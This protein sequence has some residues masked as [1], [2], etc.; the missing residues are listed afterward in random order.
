MRKIYLS[1]LLICITFSACSLGKKSYTGT[2]VSIEAKR[3][4]S[5]LYFNRSTL[6]LHQLD[7]GA[8]KGSLSILEDGETIPFD[9]EEGYIDDKKVLHLKLKATVSVLF[10]S[11]DV[12]LCLDEEPSDKEGY[13]K[14]SAYL[15][16]DKT[17]AEEMVFRKV[18]EQNID[19]ELKKMKEA[20]IPEQ[21]DYL[22][23][24]IDNKKLEEATTFYQSIKK[25]GL[26]FTKEEEI[27]NK[28]KKL[29]DEIEEEKRRI[30]AE[31]ERIEAE[32]N[33]ADSEFK[34][35]ETE[36]TIDVYMSHLSL[37]DGIQEREEKLEEYLL[38]F[39]Q[40]IEEQIIKLNNY[41]I[42]ADRKNEKPD[43]EKKGLP[44]LKEKIIKLEAYKRKIREF[45][46]Q[47]PKPEKQKKKY[48]PFA[49]ESI[50]GGT[51]KKVLTVAG[52]EKG[53]E[54]TYA[55]LKD[56]ILFLSFAVA[57][58]DYIGGEVEKIDKD[59][60][61]VNFSSQSKAFKVEI[62]EEEIKQQFGRRIDFAFVDEYLKKGD[63]DKAALI[64][65][66]YRETEES[67]TT[68]M[69]YVMA[70]AY[71]KSGK[72]FS[73][74]EKVFIDKTINDIRGE[75]GNQEVQQDIDKTIYYYQLLSNFS[76]YRKTPLANYFLARCYAQ[77]GDKEK[78]YQHLD[79][80]LKE[81]FFYA[82]NLDDEKSFDI[83]RNENKFQA[84]RY[85]MNS[86][87]TTIEQKKKAIS[88]L[89]SYVLDKR[90]YD[91]KKAVFANRYQILNL[92]ENIIAS[93]YMKEMRNIYY[94][95]ARYAALC[96]QMD[97]A[98]TYL[99][100]AT[101]EGYKSSGYEEERRYEFSSI[102]DTE[103]FKEAI[104]MMEYNYRKGRLETI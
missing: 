83:V 35:G 22:N 33:K 10:F 4:K 62:S 93:G 60:V 5:S 53:I 59:K 25:Q 85:E 54:N 15:T 45:A 52:M 39:L 31:K 26:T 14:F 51:E 86:L 66:K 38:K 80:A 58:A 61:F 32:L 55:A 89:E 24:L 1:I 90:E 34:S 11:Q 23:Q 48:D 28:I 68:E 104:K 69:R 44:A 7:N 103:S 37:V 6:V 92:Y 77:K 100:R 3:D 56:K 64:L 29:Q 75:L 12:P 47:T 73:P 97:K 99:K 49:F 78:T 8:F 87:I 71:L 50:F 94:N 95:A 36:Q 41:A 70:V 76:P 74:D 30:A 96:G 79:L 65:E 63:I 67:L 98:I 18:D 9:L 101:L 102:K 2:Y 17:K 72:M 16:G 40:E 43:F 88:H 84:I 81:G 82:G 21:V 27:K 19:T 42:E 20:L 46:K 91:T 57:I 13:L